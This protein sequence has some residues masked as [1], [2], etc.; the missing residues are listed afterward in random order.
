M[1]LEDAFEGVQQYKKLCN[2]LFIKDES[3]CIRSVT[4]PLQGF[5]GGATRYLGRWCHNFGIIIS[6]LKK[7]FSALVLYC[8]EII[9]TGL[10]SQ[11]IIV[12]FHPHF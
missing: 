1:I 7:K 10:L 11:C 9:C 4:I 2:F 12:V 6:I 5:A 3:K 8:S